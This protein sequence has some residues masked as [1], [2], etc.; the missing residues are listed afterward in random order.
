MPLPSYNQFL[1]DVQEVIPA[2]NANG[3]F[4]VANKCFVTYDQAESTEKEMLDL[5]EQ[6]QYN[7]LFDVEN[8]N[9]VLFPVVD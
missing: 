3:Y 2:M 8:R 9:E 4:S 6:V 1:K 5:Y 7:N